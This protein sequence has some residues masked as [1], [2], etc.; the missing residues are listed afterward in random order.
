MGG[1][2]RTARLRNQE[3]RALAQV[4]LERPIHLEVPIDLNG[5]VATRRRIGRKTAH[6]RRPI[7]RRHAVR[8]NPSRDPLPPMVQHFEERVE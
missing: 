7:R 1:G 2:E 4:L 8:H 3:Q 5:H 6:G